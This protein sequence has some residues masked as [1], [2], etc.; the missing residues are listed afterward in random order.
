MKFSH[1]W[2]QITKVLALFEANDSSSG[3][4]DFIIGNRRRTWKNESNG[5]SN[6]IT[7]S[8][9]SVDK[10][11]I[12]ESPNISKRKLMLEDEMDS[13]GN[14]KDEFVAQS[15]KGPSICIYR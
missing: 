3:P 14:R 15:T 7:P 11:Q 13:L 1:F 9:S 12:V 2:K 8:L 5:L 6:N 10:E 4:L